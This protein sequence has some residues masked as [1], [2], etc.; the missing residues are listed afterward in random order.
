MSNLKLKMVNSVPA[1]QFKILRNVE[2][3]F[4]EDEVNEHLSDGWTL[5]GTP[6]ILTDG[7]VAQAI[8]S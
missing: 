3:S 7:E 1:V 6:F 2:V 4:L 5:H 8:V